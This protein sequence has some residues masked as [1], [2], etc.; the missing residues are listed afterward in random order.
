[1][2]PKWETECQT[3]LLN[4]FLRNEISPS[5]VLGYSVEKNTISALQF[6]DK[7]T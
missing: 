7:D 5:K 6:S 3:S 4:Q 1:M 2:F